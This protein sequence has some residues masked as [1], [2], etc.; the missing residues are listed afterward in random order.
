M[1]TMNI[2]TATT[3]KVLFA[4]FYIGKDYFGIDV[5]MVQEILQ[6]Q[7]MTPV[8]K[9]SEY[10]SG[11][12]NLRGQIVTALD[13]GYILKNRSRKS[14]EECMHIVINTAE[15]TL[16]LLVDNIDDVLEL[17]TNTIEPVPSTL[18]SISEEY[19][20]GV[21]KLENKLLLSLDISKVIDINTTLA[22]TS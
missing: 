17:D 7:T 4:T 1:E 9:A 12:I 2:Q 8:P 10:V 16:S 14:I 11:L 20:K 13:L 6:P 21:Y 3:E 15:G 22:K 5:Q 19:L 18:K